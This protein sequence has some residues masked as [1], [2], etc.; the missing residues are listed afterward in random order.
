MCDS[1]MNAAQVHALDNVEV[2]KLMRQK[3]QREEG[4][5]RSADLP[6]PEVP[7]LTRD[8]LESLQGCIP[9]AAIK[10]GRS[11]WYPAKLCHPP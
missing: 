10:E 9:G 1:P 6:N 4:L 11:K 7:K 5:E 8:K 2:R 3:K